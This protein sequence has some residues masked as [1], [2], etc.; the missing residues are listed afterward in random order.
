M[1]NA[2]RQADALIQR[3]FDSQRAGDVAQA[4]SAYEQALHW[5]AE[6]PAALQLLGLLARRRGDAA[7]AES[8]MRRSLASDAR[9]PHVWNNLGNLLAHGSRWP[10]ALACFER[11]LDLSATYAD[12]HYNR[13]R[14]LCTLGRQADALAALARAQALSPAANTAMQQLH[15]RILE[16]QADL[17]AALA[18]LD[19]ALRL[20]PDKPA[21][22]HNRATLLQRFHRPAEALQS[23][24]RA[25]ALGLDV[26]DAHYNHGNTLQSMGRMDD[27][28]AAYRRALARQPL[29]R[30]ALYD[31]A[32]LR[33]RLGEPG[34][35]RELLDAAAAH[36][37]S[38]LAPGL[39][40]HLLLRA[41][42]YADAAAC[43]EQALQCDPP[44]AVFHD[45][46]ARA[47]ARLGR[48][49][50]SLAHHAHAVALAP[51]DAPLRT[52]HATT[53]LM[54]RRA[55]AAAVQ[56]QA[57]C[58]LGPDDQQ[59][60]A[61]LG[62]AWRLSGDPREPWLNDMARL[63]SVVDLQ[64][65]PGFDDME[66]FN[67]ALAQELIA[68][69]RDR[70]APMDQ[71]L[72]GGTQTVGDIFEQAHPLVDALKAV[73]SQAVQAYIDSL[74]VDATHPFL[75]RRAAGWRFTDSWSSR[76][77][78]GGF[79]TPHVHPHGWISS[80]FYVAVPA[81]AQDTTRR[82]GWLHLGRPEF[83]EGP[84]AEA[85]R[86]VQPRVGRLVLFPS[87]FWHGT[88]PFDDA[89]ARLTIAF[90]AVPA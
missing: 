5:Q 35:D 87:M 3:G 67:R 15:A 58:E 36:P 37:Q 29:H 75:S 59:A 79:H 8:L 65:P 44:A 83:G 32:R 84:S 78:S 33:W 34:F 24:E 6:H 43:F 71:T 51:A 4:Q 40:G 18:V 11:A 10:E 77:R 48:L 28:V 2:K 1:N 74:P 21:L 60:W 31:L 76:L 61:L 70:V 88:T 82:E 89:Q 39:R 63:V 46:L 57:A 53:L 86:M 30:L 12:A 45:G 26:A 85:R 49:D 72:R 38:S 22:L 56:A 14:V 47:L 23:H 66:S 13:A 54:A 69:H 64:A 17:P 16:A 68:L 19:E 52:S 25:L 9:Q 80:V 27:A 81:A 7:Q 42:R 73:I 20:S 55:D 50:E 62:L 41:E 90:D